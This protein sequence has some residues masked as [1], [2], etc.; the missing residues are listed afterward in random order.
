MAE[1]QLLNQ[2]SGIP[3]SDKIPV[4]VFTQQQSLEDESNTKLQRI[5]LNLIQIFSTTEANSFDQAKL[6]DFVEI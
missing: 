6:N 2:N 5:F 1:N 4:L 3:N